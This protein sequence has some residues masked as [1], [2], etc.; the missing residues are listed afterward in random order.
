M[1]VLKNYWYEI[2]RIVA[3][4]LL[5]L[6]LTIDEGDL[7]VRVSDQIVA[8]P[9]VVNEFNDGICMKYSMNFVITF[10]PTQ[11]M[12]KLKK[13]S[14]KLGSELESTT[15]P[16]QLFYFSLQKRNICS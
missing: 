9:V 16:T 1:K 6:S 4:R 2:Y 12:R 15:M 5:T 14:I 7:N 8:E 11:S 13:I 3:S 10:P